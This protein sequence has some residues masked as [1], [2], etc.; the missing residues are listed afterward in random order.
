[1]LVGRVGNVADWYDRAEIFVLS[2][3]YEGFPNSLLEAMSHG[4]AVV[5][6]ACDT[7]P[8]DIVEHAG[9]GLLVEPNQGVTGLADAMQRL[10]SDAEQRRALAIRAA[11]VRERFA[12]DAIGQQWETLL[13]IASKP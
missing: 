12:L 7:G 1:M 11:Q 5:S 6:F 3:R 10:M 13:G 4:L 9:N 8:E 2:S